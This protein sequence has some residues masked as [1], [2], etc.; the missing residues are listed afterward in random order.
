MGL[1]GATDKFIQKPF[2]IKSVFQGFYSSIFA[3]FMLMGSIKLIQKDTL[4]VLEISDLKIIGIV[5]IFVL[6]TGT[7][8]SIV[9]TFFAV[10]KY[11]KLTENQLYN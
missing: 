11:I 8:L 7:F 6:F 10:K 4:K 5:F 2:I 3:I 9:S 1:V